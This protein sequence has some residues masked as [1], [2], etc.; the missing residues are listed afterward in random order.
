M[1][2]LF[3]IVGYFVAGVCVIL[4]GV[5]CA[6]EQPAASA[7]PAAL[8]GGVWNPGDPGV[9]LLVT[10][11]ER[12]CVGTLVSRRAVVTAAH[13]AAA[14]A[15]RSV[16]FFEPAVDGGRRGHVDIGVGAASV[17]AGYAKEPSLHD[18]AVLQL[19]DDAPAWATPLPL[20]SVRQ[21]DALHNGAELR[22]IGFTRDFEKQQGTTVIDAVD[23]F[24][25]FHAASP[26]RTCTGDSG[27]PA[28]ISVAGVEYL[29]G[30]AADGDGA[31]ER[32]GRHVRVDAHTKFLLRQIPELE[33]PDG[34]FPVD[35][36][37][38]T[39]HTSGGCSVVRVTRPKR[40]RFAAW[41]ALGVLTL[42]SRRCLRRLPLHP[43]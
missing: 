29:A 16:R 23:E 1:P 41:F 37:D 32:F 26:A 30:V 25:F 20:L 39:Q 2:E 5:A 36:V 3:R 40:N 17:Q 38:R 8:I 18:I 22:L 33:Q 24:D 14:M 19:V 34:G 15:E 42:L 31:C 13:C 12:L 4:H 28:L 9:V 6:P 10:G 35:I 21:S 43:R 27:G 7:S 11:G